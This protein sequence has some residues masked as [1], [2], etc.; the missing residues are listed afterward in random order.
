MGILLGSSQTQSDTW[1]NRYFPEDLPADWRY[2]YY[3]NDYPV[4]LFDDRGRDSGSYSIEFDWPAEL[5]LVVQ[6]DAASAQN[7]DYIDSLLLLVNTHPQ[8]LFLHQEIAVCEQFQDLGVGCQPW[9]EVDSG[10]SV[11]TADDQSAFFQIHSLHD[12]GGDLRALRRRF[13]GIEQEAVE[14]WVFLDS[15][16]ERLEQIKVMLDLMGIRA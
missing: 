2:S 16:P 13:E 1:L 14:S 5:K 4:I 9:A 11:Y 15:T 8:L 7:N 10:D 12:P 3:V 6:P